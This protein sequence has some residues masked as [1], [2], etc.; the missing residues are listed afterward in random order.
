VEYSNGLFFIL[1][2]NDTNSLGEIK[3]IDPLNSTLIKDV[4]EAKTHEPLNKSNPYSITFAKNEKTIAI[5]NDNNVT[6]LRFDNNKKIIDTKI[7]PDK[8]V[9]ANFIYY[10]NGKL[11]YK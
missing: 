4:Y 1:I 9:Y 7:I 5:G 2:T 8:D 11:Y 6:L 3:I 10:E